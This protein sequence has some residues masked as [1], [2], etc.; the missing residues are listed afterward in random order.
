MTLSRIVGL[1]TMLLVSTPPPSVLATSG[2]VS[3]LEFGADGCNA[4]HVGGAAP[5]VELTGPTVVEP[6]STHE[7]VLRVSTVGTQNRAGLNVSAPLGTLALGG[8]D[9]AETRVIAGAGGLDEITQTNGKLAT[10]GAVV[11]TFLWK[12]PRRFG[13]ATLTAWGN[14]VDGNFSG[15]GDRAAKASLTV[16]NANGIPDPT[17]TPGGATPSPTPRKLTNPIGPPIRKGGITVRLETVA[18]DL[19]APVWATSAPGGDPR[20]LF[21]VDQPGILWR[22]DVTTGTKSVF[23][24]VRD[25]LVPLGV[26]GP[27]TYDERG[28][29]GLA[30]DP[31]Y[32]ANGTLY[33]YTSEPAR[34]DPDFS[35]IPP[36][37]SP[38]H[39]SVLIAWRV[40]D[41]TNPSAVVDSASAHVLLRIDEPQFNHNGGCLG[42][43]PDGMLYMSLG[44]GG[45]ADDEDGQPFVGGP[46][47]G[48]GADGNG[49]NLSV[50]LG[51]LLRLDP[52]GSDAANG[53]YGIPPGNPF[54]GVA[55]ALPEIWAFGLRNP[56]SFS[57]DALGGALF[58]SDVGQNDIEEIDVIERGGN[59][60]WRLKEGRFRFVPNGAGAGYV[61]RMI[62]RLRTRVIDPVAEYD[63]GE[64]ISVIGGHVYR[65]SQI[66][67]LFGRYVFGEFARTFKN[68]G[69]LFY[70]TSKNIG[71]T[72]S[73]RHSRIAELRLLGQDAL[74]V[75]LLGI[76]RDAGGE[77]YVL[78]NTTAAPFGDTGVVR[79]IAA[80]PKRSALRGTVELFGGK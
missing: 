4:C 11:F 23:L 57:F 76:G 34:P 72:G 15:A 73:S 37:L 24:D 46:T 52:H 38:D 36:G 55:G 59:Y 64:G 18:T 53:R 44:D 26:F 42:F 28:F 49:Q 54:L 29:L 14:A 43:G 33:T 6:E 67:R 61:T 1:V 47:I 27:G 30:F 63:H 7:Y 21:V 9:S 71:G 2:G 32:A 31:G 12:A 13:N 80:A 51:K 66:R 68:D 17:R 8:S 60:G 79:R 50:P 65:G 69:R 25:R 20:F 74:D 40:P 75:S 41:P 70:L 39:Q 78:G 10:D 77:L 5:V 35:T 62:S 22:V 56:F 58:V 48:H 19:T 45:G 3:S 16:A